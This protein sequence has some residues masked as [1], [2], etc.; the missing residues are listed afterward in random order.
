MP[1]N[2]PHSKAT[3]K[4]TLLPLT[5]SNPKATKHLPTTPR[6]RAMSRAKA[7]LLSLMGHLRRHISNSQTIHPM[8]TPNL[9][10]VIRSTHLKTI[11]IQINPISHSKAIRPS[12][13]HH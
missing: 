9:R 10:Q 13:V 12:L 1:T 11:L 4:A 8:G 5:I 2:L 7:I 6:I 3:N